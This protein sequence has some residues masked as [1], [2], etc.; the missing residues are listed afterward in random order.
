MNKELKS[1]FDKA[2]EALEKSMQN[3][4][5]LKEALVDEGHAQEGEVVVKLFDASCKSLMRLFKIIRKVRS[6]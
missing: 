5:I 4:A 3:L 2:V 1:K 6:K